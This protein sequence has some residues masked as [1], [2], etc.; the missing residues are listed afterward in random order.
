M[1]WNI[2]YEAS[3]VTEL[4]RRYNIKGAEVASR[5]YEARKVLLD[6]RDKRYPLLADGKVL[7]GWNGLAVAAL[8]HAAV[9]FNVPEW[10][11]IA[12]RTALFITKNFPAKNGGWFRVWVDGK[13]YIPAMAEDYA[14]FLWGIVELF[15]AAKHFNAGEKQLDDWLQTAKTLADILME[16]FGDEKLGGLFA[17]DGNISGLR[18]KSPEDTNSLPSMNAVAAMVLDELAFLLEDKKYSDFA[19]KIIGC[20]SRYSRENPTRCLSMITADLMFKPFKPKKKVEPPPKPVP[21]DEELNREDND[22]SAEPSAE[23]R[24]AARASRRS[25]RQETSS[26]TGKNDRTSRRSARS[27]RTRER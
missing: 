12:E 6:Y 17:T 10:K 9:S 24:K 27:H 26:Q 16:K 1:S 21:T 23:D 14:Y 7:M 5:L 25:A 13:T 4:A 11:D 3:T 19:R 18:L 2:L 20:F 22:A 8:A 15:K